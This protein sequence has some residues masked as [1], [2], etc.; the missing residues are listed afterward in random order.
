MYAS[1]QHSHSLLSIMDLSLE[2]HG[3]ETTSPRLSQTVFIFKNM[4]F[5][6]TKP[7]VEV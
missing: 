5:H 2:S 6:V 3:R 7:A 4:N 1:L